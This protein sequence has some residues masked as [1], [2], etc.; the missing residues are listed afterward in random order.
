MRAINVLL[1]VEDDAND[2]LLTQRK[3]ER[4][5]LPVGELVV[6]RTLVDAIRTLKSREIDVVLLDLNLGSESHGLETLRAVRPVYD[7][8]VIVMTSIDDEMVGIEA[9]RIG[10]EEFLV[11]GKVTEERLRHAVAFSQVRYD[12][13]KA[14]QRMDANINKLEKILSQG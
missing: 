3:I 5:N 12:A 6:A 10:A 11:K 7:G 9:I 13:K 8:V 4:A 1:L 14:G 2:V